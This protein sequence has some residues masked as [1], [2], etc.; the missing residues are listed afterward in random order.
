VQY[1]EFL[2]S[3][4][5][6]KRYWARNFIGWPRFSAV[7]P[8]FTHKKLA[9]MEKEL[10]ILHVVTQNVDNL[11]GKAGS[12]EFTELHGNGY[13]VICIGT[14]GK[15]RCDYSIDR[16]DFQQVLQ[17]FNAEL[18]EKAN[19]VHAQSFR[20]DGDVDISSSDIQKFYLPACPQCGGA[21]KPNIVFFG[22]NI[23]MPRIEKVVRLILDSDGVLVLGSSLQVFSGY[24]IILQAKELGLP[25]AVVNIGDTRADKIVDLKI[26]AKCSEILKHL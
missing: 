26:N 13:K 15:D 18:I 7:E 17:S 25:T 20:P 1:P 12:E 16:H 10:K 4:E 14:N 3:Q 24:R 19:K 2:K 8:N 21:L 5:I 11:H 22:D 23:P 6:R 9:K